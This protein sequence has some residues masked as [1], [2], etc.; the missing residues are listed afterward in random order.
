MNDNK[1]PIEALQAEINSSEAKLAALT[2][3]RAAANL[4]MQ[5]IGADV[6]RVRDV[7]RR[8]FETR[9]KIM[10]LKIALLDL[11]QPPLLERL[12]AA[13]AATTTAR[14]AYNEALEVLRIAEQV[15]HDVAVPLSTN[16][17]ARV[18]LTE[19][20]EQQHLERTLE[21]QAQT[22]GKPVLAIM[23]AY[24]RPARSQPEFEAPRR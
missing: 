18:A 4:A 7:D 19:E 17:F 6:E 20:L 21:V 10:E 13:Q 9:K 11:E 8:I 23:G 14:A 22:T 16:A 5:T 1:T 12:R 24:G 2:G 15:E 3:E